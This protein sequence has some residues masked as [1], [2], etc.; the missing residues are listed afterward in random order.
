MSPADQPATR[1]DDVALQQLRIALH[2]REG[3][4]IVAALTDRPLLDVAHLA[5]DGLVH[6]VEQQADGAQE[7]AEQLAWGLGERDETGDL[8]LA[9]ELAAAC[10]TS[11]PTALRPLPVDLDQVAAS[12]EG[13]DLFD[14]GWRIDVATGR[15]WPE[16]PMDVIG[17][18]PPDHWDD[19]EAWLVVEPLGSSD[20][21]QDMRDFISLVEDSRLAEQLEAAIRGRGAFRRFGD[22]IHREE[23]LS[24]RWRLFTD[25]RQLGRARHWLAAHGFRPA[26]PTTT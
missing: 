22:L 13:Q 2:G 3:P 26:P 9:A 24:R 18:A 25:Q 12:L 14:P 8:E 15:W 20:G 1:W 5:G 6:A 17:E 19:D 11:A 21:W 23:Q 10:S 7:L 16:D 4:A